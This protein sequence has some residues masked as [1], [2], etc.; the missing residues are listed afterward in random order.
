M[1]YASGVKTISETPAAI[2]VTP[3]V[4]G[5]DPVA[6]AMTAWTVITA[7]TTARAAATTAA[8]RVSAAC[9]WPGRRSSARNR[10]TRA[11]D[12]VTSAS[13]PSPTA[14]TLKL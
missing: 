6:S 11:A 10:Q 14:S 13:T 4:P 7:L 12:P 1:A 9:D 2:K 3:D 8:A 5:W